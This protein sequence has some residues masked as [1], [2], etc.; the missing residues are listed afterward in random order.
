MVL[1]SHLRAGQR[2]QIAAFTLSG[3]LAG[4]VGIAL[5]GWG[6]TVDFVRVVLSAASGTV[7][8]PENQSLLAA[9]GRTLTTTEHRYS[10]FTAADPQPVT[11]QALVEVPG[12]AAPVGWALVC[13]NLATTIVAL[14][15]RPVNVPAS[16]ALL[17]CAALVVTPVVWDHYHV[18]LV[19]PALVLLGMARRRCRNGRALLASPEAVALA[20]LFLGVHRFWKPLTL[21]IAPSPLFL[22]FGLLAAV[23]LWFALLLRWSGREP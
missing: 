9:V 5:A 6:A 13:A 14:W 4:A 11:I 21:L 18:L 15:R 10:A 12:L 19:L 17:L 20:A 23:T 8:Q 7:W 22:L 16:L 2:R 3:L 1:L